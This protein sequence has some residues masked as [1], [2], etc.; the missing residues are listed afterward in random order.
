MRDRREASMKPSSLI[1]FPGHALTHAPQ[2]P[3]VRQTRLVRLKFHRRYNFS[4]EKARPL[5]GNYELV[6]TSYKSD[7]RLT[8]PIS[9]AYRSSVDTYTCLSAKL[10]SNYAC[11]QRQAFT[12]HFM[13]VLAIGIKRK[14]RKRSVA[15]DREG[16]N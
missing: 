4:Q 6:I 14:F 11:K 1:A 2:S 7:S 13:V 9:L 10:L 3:Q 16:N 8:G 15:A 12:Y 5:A